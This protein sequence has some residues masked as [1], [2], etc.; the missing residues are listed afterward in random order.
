[1]KKYIEGYNGKIKHFYYYYYYYY[2]CII[3]FLLI[4][5]LIFVQFQIY[6]KIEHSFH[7]YSVL[8]RIFSISNILYQHG[9]FITINE[10]ILKNGY[11][12]KFILFK[13]SQFLPNVFFL[14]Q[15]PIQNTLHLVSNHYYLLPG[16]QH[17]LSN[18]SLCFHYLC[19]HSHILIFFY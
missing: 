2:H 8:Y 1:M 13:F 12:Q 18:K 5:A 16:L 10:T 4:I 3:L 19:F 7:I 14:F 15:N 11:S 9:T 17:Q 6:G